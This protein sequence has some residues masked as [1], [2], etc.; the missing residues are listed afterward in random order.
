MTMRPQDRPRSFIAPHRDD[1]HDAIAIVCMALT[2]AL[3]VL[4][5]RIASTLA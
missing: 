1:G 3:I 2:L 4:A 5:W